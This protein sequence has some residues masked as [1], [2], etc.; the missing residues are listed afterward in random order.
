MY[1]AGHI[2]LQLEAMKEDFAVVLE[3]GKIVCEQ[4]KMIAE[5][6]A[7]AS[8]ELIGKIEDSCTPCTVLVQGVPAVFTALHCACSRSA[9]GD[10]RP[11]HP[12]R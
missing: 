1:K 3:Q 12:W 6:A 4:S 2:I 11:A 8:D 10:Y 7:K 9:R 5:K